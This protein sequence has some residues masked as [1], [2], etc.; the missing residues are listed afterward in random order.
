VPFDT[1]IADFQLGGKINGIDVLKGQQ[2]TAPGKQLILI[3]AFGSPEV[4][5]EAKA[6]GA[7]YLEKPFLLKD[8][9]S[10]IRA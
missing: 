1:V 5:S 6:M 8:L 10:Q 2:N 3:T 7:V 4:Q 9:I